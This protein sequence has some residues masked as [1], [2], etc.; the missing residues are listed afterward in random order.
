MAAK[1]EWDPSPPADLLAGQTILVTGAGDGIGAAVARLLAAHGAS[2]V[3][4][5]RTVKKLETV[6]DEI[7]SLGGPTPAIFPLDLLRATPEDALRLAEGIDDTFG[8]LDGLLHNASVLGTLSPIAHYEPQ[9]W[10]EVMQVNVNAAFLLT[11]ALLPMLERSTDARVVFTSSGVGRAGRAHWGA[12]CVS[13]F[14]TEGLMQVLADETEGQ[15]RIK[16]MCINPGGTRTR[17]RAAAFPAEDPNA[18][19]TPDEIA[20]AYLHLFGPAGAGLHGQ[21]VDA[22]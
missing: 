15:G 3:L 10:L 20:P 5:G 17:M 7:E 18:L 21:S 4:L 22:S 1:L 13:K 16:V 19:P 14:A 11:S 12:Y 2:L 8:R 9:T 6:Y